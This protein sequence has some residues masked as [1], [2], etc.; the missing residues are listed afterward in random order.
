MSDRYCAEI[1]IGGKV[2][3]SKIAGLISAIN[4]QECRTGWGGSPVDLGDPEEEL[5]Y[6]IGKLKELIWDEDKHTGD[7][8]GLLWLCDPEARW[9][10]LDE[11]R[12]YCDENDIGYHHFSEGYG[13]YDP[14]VKEF[15]PGWD[16]FDSYITD[17]DGNPM[18]C[19]TQVSPLLD[20]LNHVDWTQKVNPILVKQI[21]KHSKALRSLLPK[22]TEP[23]EP[24]EIIEG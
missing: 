12:G 24:F 14:E 8:K 1:S 18:N 23:L 22:K 16:E 11:I 6:A 21:I 5:D 15:R 9:G 10:E 7:K 3:K 13:E 2:P 4:S 17:Q 19:G 20:V